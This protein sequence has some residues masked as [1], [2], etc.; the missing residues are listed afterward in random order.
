MRSFSL[1]SFILIPFLGSTGGRPSSG[2][3]NFFGGGRSSRYRFGDVGGGNVLV[4]GDTDS[5]FGRGG[6]DELDEA[7]GYLW[8]D[9]SRYP[10][11]TLQE[12]L[13]E[14]VRWGG[15]PI[16][17]GTAAGRSRSSGKVIGR[18]GGG[19]SPFHVDD[20]E[21]ERFMI[22]AFGRLCGRSYSRAARGL[23]DGPAEDGPIPV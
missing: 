19:S 13:G 22:S 10:S 17:N 14:F 15:A 12:A 1:S 7:G 8:L 18:R 16:A 2:G 5:G 21:A 6:R 9:D 4:C 23:K 20:F 11:G 3:S